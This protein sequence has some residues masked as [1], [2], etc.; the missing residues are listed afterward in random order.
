MPCF[1]DMRQTPALFLREMKEW[2]CGRGGF[3]EGLREEEEGEHP[4][5]KI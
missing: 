1:V 5:P 2:L 3:G 4:G